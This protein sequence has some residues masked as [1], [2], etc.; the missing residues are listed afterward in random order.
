MKTANQFPTYLDLI[1]TTI[2]N[3]EGDPDNS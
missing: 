1:P 2:C 3:V